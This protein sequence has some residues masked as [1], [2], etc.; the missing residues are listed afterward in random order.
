MLG[1]RAS[2]ATISTERGRFATNLA[3]TERYGR[4]SEF[5][6]RLASVLLRRLRQRKLCGK[7]L[8]GLPSFRHSG[9]AYETIVLV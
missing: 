1:K 6:H 8:N 3:S 9:D 4:Y 7:V 2:A 5:A